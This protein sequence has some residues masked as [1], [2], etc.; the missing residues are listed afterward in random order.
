MEFQR[1]DLLR[2]NHAATAGAGTERGT[3]IGTVL[4]RRAVVIVRLY[5]GFPAAR[6]G[7]M[8]VL[9][10]VAREARQHKQV[11]AEDAEKLVHVAKVTGKMG[12]CC[13]G[14]LSAKS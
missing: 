6:S 1:S 10:V 13:L 3:E 4:V 11:Q 9:A 5:N 2:G 14:S 12:Y 7:I 8:P